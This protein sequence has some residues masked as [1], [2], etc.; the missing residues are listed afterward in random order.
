[1]CCRYYVD[2]SPE[3]RPIIEEANRSP[4]R[5]KM[6]AALGAPF[7]AS[8][9]VYPGQIVPVIATSRSG[10]RSAFPM[11]WG[12]QVPGLRSPVL[13]ARVESAPVKKTFRESWASRRCVIPASW[14]FEWEHVPQP[15][16]SRRAGRKFA[17]QPRGLDVT[18]LGGLYRMENGFPVFVV[19]TREP[20]DELRFIHD[21]MPLI[22]PPSAIDDWIRPDSAPGKVLPLALTDAV[23]EESA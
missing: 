21:R 3:L 10:G 16:G 18:Y 4:L 11:F 2:L 8:G 13:N 6:V 22:L 15:D 9:E 14:Y 7:V 23:W 17:I 12:F 1:M 19:L 20:A 5:E